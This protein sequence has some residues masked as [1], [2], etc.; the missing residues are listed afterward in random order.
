MSTVRTFVL[1]LVLLLVGTLTAVAQSNEII[2]SILGQQ[3]ATVASAAYLALSAADLVPDDASP[4]RAYET[5]VQSGWLDAD[6]AADS[7]ATFGQAAHLLMQAF[8][9]PGGLMYRIFTGPRYAAREFE[10]QQWVPER[11]SPREQISGEFL[12][13][14][15]GS[16]LDNR[17]VT[18]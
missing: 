10:Y 12:I 14:M 15:A 9:V 2:D 11:H 5:A 8:E 17:E 6:V 16:F 4:Q 3:P 7:A 13:R 18:Q 1:F